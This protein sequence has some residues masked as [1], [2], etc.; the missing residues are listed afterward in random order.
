MQKENNLTVGQWS[1]HWFTTNRQKWN[2]NTEGGYRNLIYSHIIRYNTAKG[3]EGIIE[4]H[5]IPA[6]G[7]IKLK[8]LSS[9][10]IQRMYNDLKENGR[11]P[12]GAKQNDKPL[13][14]TFV[15]R[16]HAVLQAALKQAVEERH[17]RSDGNGYFGGACV[18]AF[19]RGNVRRGNC[20]C[21][22]EREKKSLW[23]HWWTPSNTL[24]G[25]DAFPRPP[26]LPAGC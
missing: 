15:R 18:P 13:S 17:K 21:S 4:H 9:I 25:V 3:Y 24:S 12:R 26:H 14:N 16:V 11:M 10:H 7:A 20:G 22:G 2:G 8:Q 23:W 1:V 6:I 19:G 5:I